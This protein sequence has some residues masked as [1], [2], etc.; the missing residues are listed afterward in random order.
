MLYVDKYNH[1]YLEKP[2]PKIKVSEYMTIKEACQKWGIE[3][4][5]ARRIVSKVPNAK[6]VVINGRNTWIIPHEAQKPTKDINR[7]K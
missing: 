6:Q 5:W 4:S 7:E 1:V 2:S 3:S